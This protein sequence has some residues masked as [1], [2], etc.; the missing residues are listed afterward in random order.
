MSFCRNVGIPPLQVGEEMLFA[1]LFCRK[2]GL[3]CRVG[4]PRRVG[5]Y[6]H[7]P[8]H[9]L[10]GS[11]HTWVLSHTGSAACKA[12]G[13]V[14]SLVLWLERFLWLPRA[15]EGG[16]LRVGLG[17][18]GEQ[19]ECKWQWDCLGAAGAHLSAGVLHGLSTP[20]IR[21]TG[22][23]WAVSSE[24]MGLSS[25]QHICFFRLGG[26]GGEWGAENNQGV[27]VFLMRIL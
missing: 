27:I 13:P 6:G 15:E 18:P 11:C 1:F 17:S 22:G 10:H 23:T 3:N 9:Y 26:R 25:S 4:G 14:C 7:P 2:R 20:G 8:L 19:G 21:R 5:L 24:V 12:K 16:R